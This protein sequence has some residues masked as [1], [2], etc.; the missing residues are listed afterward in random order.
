MTFLDGPNAGKSTTTDGNGA[1]RFEGL[2]SGN[3]NLA[4]R[5]N[6]FEEARRGDN[7]IGALTMNFTLRTAQPF[8]RT[9]TGATVFDLPSYISRVRITG[10]YNGFC[11]NFVLKF[12]GRL[13]VNEILG[14]CSVGSGR[15]YDGT[16]LVT[17][18]TVEVTNSTG[19]AWSVTEVR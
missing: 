4:A 3:A 16:H 8:T 12:A 18:G 10:T 14:S 17:A 13:I 15:T 19:I 7:V 5:A 2:T 9:G 1:Y 11:E 6:G